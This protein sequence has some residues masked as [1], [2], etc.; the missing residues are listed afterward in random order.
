VEQAVLKAE[1]EKRQP[2][3]DALKAWLPAGKPLSVS[4]EDTFSFSNATKKL[5]TCIDSPISLKGMS[6][7]KVDS[8]CDLEAR[9]DEALLENWVWCCGR[10]TVVRM[11]GVFRYVLLAEGHSI[12]V[13]C[14]DKEKVDSFYLKVRLM[15]A[16]FDLPRL[17]RPTWPDV[18]HRL[19]LYVYLEKKEWLPAV[20]SEATA[21]PGASFIT[22]AFKSVEKGFAPTRV[23]EWKRCIRSEGG[24][25]AGLVKRV[26]A[27]GGGDLRTGVVEFEQNPEV[28]S[29]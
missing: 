19:Y 22:A 8:I 23:A 9:Q 11:V 26:T 1:L 5:S 24:L 17:P 2:D 27:L 15:W 21:F 25:V 28:F 20:E 16:Y 10:E 7:K 6:S 14:E 29:D 3:L 12:N 13:V 4:K 18:A